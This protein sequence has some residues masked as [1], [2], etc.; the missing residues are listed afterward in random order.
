MIPKEITEDVVM[1]IAT[2]K[3]QLEG[4]IKMI[5]DDSDPDKILT[6][7]KAA[8]L[9]QIPPQNTVDAV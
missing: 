3:G 5:N 7:F 4:I 8:A 1:R 9:P 6:Q 2:V